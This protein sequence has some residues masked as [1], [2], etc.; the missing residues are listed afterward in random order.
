M[1]TDGFSVYRHVKDS[2]K[3]VELSYALLN[4]VSVV[5]CT[6]NDLGRVSSKLSEFIE[7]KT[8]TWSIDFSV[9]A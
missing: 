6:E 2:I 7:K 4:R 1:G 8:K 9:I 5:T 3:R